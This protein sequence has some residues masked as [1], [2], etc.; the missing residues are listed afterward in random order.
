[1]I[2]V[3]AA[4]ALLWGAAGYWRQPSG[5]RAATQGDRPPFDTSEWKTDFHAH[6]VSFTDILSGG[7]PK[8]GIPAVDQPNF[9]SVADADKW[10]S[11]KEPVIL[12]ERG[13]EARAYPLQVLIWH[14]IANDT[15]AGHP[16]AITFCPLCNTSIVFDRRLDGRV[17]DFGTTGKLRFS[18][19]VMYDRQTESWWQQATGEAIVGE[20]TGKRLVFLPSQV[21]SW[22]TFR[23]THPSGKVL[24]RETGHRRPYGSNPY[25][26]YDDVNSSPFLYHGPKDG[27]LP[28]MERVVTLSLNG[29]D[30]AYPFSVMEKVRLVNDTAGGR[31]VVILY[32]KGVTSALDR[33]SIPDSRDVGTAGIFERML[34]GK[35]LTFKSS[36]IRFVDVQ[37]QSTWNILGVATS[38]PLAGKRLT[39]V[40]SGSHFWFSW[41]V[42][43]PTTRIFKP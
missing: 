20:L 4:V 18:D 3:T 17:L 40:V 14:E 37:T 7:P 28:P 43:K 24:N 41:V 5:A 1:M 38:G 33:S 11:S 27:R 10:L 8:D 19:L 22:E 25:V 26:G 15:V 13:G 34:D 21:I 42:F 2:A 12:V 6:S 16:V 29:D 32:A 9:D 30:V 35:V 23:L 31:P 39:P 36:G